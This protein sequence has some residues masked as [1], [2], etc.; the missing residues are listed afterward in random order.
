MAIAPS[1]FAADAAA[2]NRAAEFF[3]TRVRPVLADSCISCHG[4]AK[5]RGGLRLDSR[6]ALLKGADSGLVL[7]EGQ[8]DKS[9]LV[10]AVRYADQIKMPPAPKTKLAPEAIEALTEWVRIGAPWPDGA[11]VAAKQASSDEARKR[12]WSF[13]PVTNPAIPAVKNP[14]WVRNPI[15]AFILAKL[16]EK[17]LAPS[18]P[19]DRRTLI[20]RV[21]F[22]LI[23]LPPTPEEVEAFVA[24]PS[25]DAYEKVVDRLLASP[26]FGE[27]LG[28]HW[29]DVARYADTKGYVF[30]EDRNY[31]YSYTYRDY[32]VRA[33][34]EDLPYDQFILQQLAADRLPLGD[35]KRPLAAL[36]YLTLGRRFL[37]QTPDIIDDRIDVTMRGLQALTVGCARCHDHKFDPIPTR[38]YYSLYGVFAS[39]TEPKELPIIGPSQEPAAAAAFDA[40][41]KKRKDAVA[42]FTEAHKAEL[43]ARNVKFRNE[44]TQLKNQ[45]AK[46]NAE[47]PGG[48]QRAMAME[49]APTPVTAHVFLRGNQNNLGPEVPR[50]VPGGVGRRTTQAVHAG[51]RPARTGA[52]HC[53]QGESAD[54]AR[55]GQSRLAAPFR[56]RHQCTPSD[57]GARGE[58]PTHPELLDWL[59]ST[60]MK[61]G[62]SV[63]K[64]QRLILLSQT[65]QQD[66]R[67]DAADKAV[68]PEN[69]LLS[70]QNRF[71]LE[72]EPLR[73]ALLF[74]SE[75]LDPRMGD[76]GDDIAMGHAPFS[77]R[78]LHLRVHRPAE[79][80]GSLPHVR[81]RQPRRHGRPTAHHHHAAAGA[82]PDERFVRGGAGPRV[83]GAAR[84][85]RPGERRT[86]HRP[87]APPGLRPAG[88]SG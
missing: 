19:A 14:A 73:D 59:A 69:R 46:W 34:N 10:R 70:H 17:N 22:D 2:E 49:D 85:G 23:G 78:A 72:F 79:S 37:N 40:E 75:R 53:Q 32:V 36:G 80:A 56:R 86:A 68:D 11:A 47:A 51:Q 21:S 50:P 77:H 48:P 76:K 3:E 41:L 65:Y 5:Q 81:L 55:D 20:R 43:A 42:A 28:R 1:C 64:M 31:P 82:V 7:V 38:D 66:S 15:D 63:K 27:P 60:F 29:L 88:G 24:D 6:A 87:D 58:P 39:S 67:E 71:K 84:R 13:Q 35:D 62:W 74:V 45:V 9:S 26:H 30:T 18:Q 12:H 16:E 54:G 8:P 83:R 52:D 44:L 4:P 57:F 25:P 61:E 33:F